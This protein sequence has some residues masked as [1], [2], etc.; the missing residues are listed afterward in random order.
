MNEISSFIAVLLIWI[1]SDAVCYNLIILAIIIDNEV[2]LRF[3]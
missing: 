1:N 2:K 3:I